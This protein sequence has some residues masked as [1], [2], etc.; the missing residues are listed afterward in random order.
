MTPGPR[1]AVDRRQ[2]DLGWTLVAGAVAA[3][4]AIAV[5]E[6]LAALIPGA[7]SFVVGVGNLVI[8]LQPAGAK[9]WVAD[10]FGTADKAVLNIA[11]IV[12]ALIGGA[13]L[14][15]LARRSMTAAIGL[16]FG[17]ALTAAVIASVLDPLV[18]PVW[19]LLSAL[20][21]AGA[22]ALVLR[23]LIGLASTRLPAEMPDWPRRRF[24]GTSIAVGAAAV[25]GGLIGRLLLEERTNAGVAQPTAIP[26]P[27]ATVPPLGSGSELGVPGLSPLVT[28][29]ADFYRIDTELLTPRLDVNG[30]QLRVHGMV[31]QEVVLDY[32]DLLALPM[33]EQYVTIA[34][35][36][37][38]VGGNLV[39]NAKW[40]G[41]RLL[42]VLDMAGVHADATQVVGRSF[43][44]WTSGFPTS[45]IHAGG[46]EALIAVAMNDE[47]LPLAHG[48]PARL[49]VPGLY[50][51]V[52]ATKWLTEIQLTTLEAFD[53]YWVPLGWSK[54]A[55]ILTQSRIDTPISGSRPASGTVAVAGVAWAPD[56]GI[57]KVEVQVNDLPW[58]PAELSTPISDATWAQWLYRWPAPTGRFTLRVRATD[59]TG[60]LQ[61]PKVD[62]PPPDGAR[63]YHTISVEVA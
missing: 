20:L 43:N 44:G 53:A 56:R 8:A 62:D 52:S 34:C 51:Y 49:I 22:G 29:N 16:L 21:S 40:R 57:S 59:G 61:D 24:L 3:T 58:Q 6:L 33:H 39:G 7:P 37:N 35:V 47:P 17:V 27:V 41:A 32:G 19:A 13:V 10:V 26:D 30:W 2:P 14:G 63:G 23:T 45:W 28:P 42:D 46:R 9:Q 36:S 1:F 55:P 15:L 25:G 38:E 60:V 50:G 48:Y 18:E 54:E 5:N 4:A 12:G 31:D 11:V